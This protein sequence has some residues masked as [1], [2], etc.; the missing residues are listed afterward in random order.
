VDLGFVTGTHNVTEAEAMAHLPVQ[1]RGK[2]T[3]L[4]N[5]TVEAIDADGVIGDPGRHF[6]DVLLIRAPSTGPFSEAGDSGS[7]VVRVQGQSREIV[8]ILFGGSTALDYATPIQ[9]VL[10]TFAIQITT[11]TA[12]SAGTPRKVPEQA[13][14]ASS[15]QGARTALPPV[16][17]GPLRQRIAEVERE[18]GATKAGKS[19][20]ASVRRHMDEAQRLVNRNRRVGAAWQRHGGPL[21]VRSVL[22]SVQSADR[23]LPREIAG[24]PLELCLVEIAKVLRAHASPELVSELDDFTSAVSEL[25]GKNYKEVLLALRARESSGDRAQAA[26]VT[27]LS[28]NQ[29]SF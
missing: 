8:G 27:P 10:D 18:I 17:L 23:S 24:K 29:E 1:K 2:T 9:R 15:S 11:E 12:Q 13:A 21:L 20:V 16:P 14:P 4:T 7:A 22:Q 19:L 26:S 25:G 28:H 3:R 5:G 6:R